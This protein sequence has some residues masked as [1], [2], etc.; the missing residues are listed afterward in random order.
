[1]VYFQQ[2]RAAVVVDAHEAALLGYGVELE[3]LATSREEVASIF[4][5]VEA[6]EITAKK[7]LEQL[8]AIL[9]SLVNV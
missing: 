1:M 9:E 3:D 8:S 7:T 4:E 6:D 5:N 2:D